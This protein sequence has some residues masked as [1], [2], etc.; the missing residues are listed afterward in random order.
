[1]N[2]KNVIWNMIGTLVYS[3]A[4]ILLATIVKRIAGTGAGDDFT[5]AFTLGQTLLTIGYFEVRLFQVTDGREEYQFQDYFS[6]RLITCLLMMLACLVYL[7]VTGRRGEMYFLILLMCL[8]KMMDALADVFEGDYQKHERLDLAGK[9]LTIRTIAAVAVFTLVLL[10]IKN[11]LTAAAAMTLTAFVVICSIN[12]RMRCCYGQT[13]RLGVRGNRLWSLFSACFFLALGAFLCNCI[14]NG[15]K[16]AV[17]AYA[18]DCNYVFG[19]LFMPTAVINLFSGMIFKPVLT[20]L[21]SYY[22]RHQYRS[23]LKLLG[24]LMGVV[25]LLTVV[26][27]VGAWL[28]GV[29]VLSA[30]YAVDLAP[31]K[32]ELLILLVG[33]GLNA[34]GILVYYALVVMRRQKNILVCYAITFACTCVL[35]FYMVRRMAIRGAAIAFVLVMLVQLAVFSALLLWTCG[36]ESK[37]YENR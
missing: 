26:C 10:A 3:I 23:F 31:Y 7:L 9:S 28:L 30:I 4:T 22:D 27:I 19:A 17:D 8:F 34:A 18:S 36:K 37:E 24:V 29:P 6:F 12:P 15:V 21:T 20:T 25:V 5:F 35:P 16:F 32:T 11:V 2:K 33:G 13:S 14:L 1:M